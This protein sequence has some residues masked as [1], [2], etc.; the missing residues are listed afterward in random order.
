MP[1]RVTGEMGPD[2][3]GAVVM[4]GGDRGVG[5]VMLVVGRMGGV[6]AEGRFRAFGIADFA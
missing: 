2:V 4:V 6:T 5:A 1:L 3:E